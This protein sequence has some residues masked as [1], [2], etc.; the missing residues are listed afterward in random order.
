MKIVKEKLNELMAHPEVDKKDVHS[1]F[2]NAKDTLVAGIKVAIQ[3]DLLNNP[4]KVLDELKQYLETEI[5]ERGHWPNL[6]RERY[7]DPIISALE[8]IGEKT[9]E[10]QNLEEVGDLYNEPIPKDSRWNQIKKKI[11]KK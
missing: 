5:E 4:S 7:V 6:F 9:K 2:D 10:L 11:I 8:V 3:S 1:D